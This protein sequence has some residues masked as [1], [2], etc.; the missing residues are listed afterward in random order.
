MKPARFTA[1]CLLLAACSADAQAPVAEA[2]PIG[3]L[4]PPGAVADQFPR[5]ARPVAD[6]VTDTWSQ[7][8]I[9]DDAG[10]ATT[11]MRLLGVKA[12]QTIADI[13]AGSGYYTVRLAEVVGPK[14]RVIGQDIMPLYLRGLAER[15]RKTGWR[16]ITLA[17]GDP[18]DPRLPP[19]SLD[20]ALMVH[21]Y[22][23]IE[24]PYGLLWNL[25]A[26]LKPGG[27]IGIVDA[28]RPTQRHGTPP[29]LLRCELA[30]VGYRQTGFHP[31]QPGQYLAIFVLDAPP[32]S[33]AAIRPCT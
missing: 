23:E 9:R 17:L 32:A 7:E 27:I 13:G 33:P 26:S 11:V 24:Q 31:L 4:A 14:G 1:F 3:K 8:H 20:I 25:R 10:E 30:A 15:V 29:K 28:D 21:M 6:I 12:G 5:P 19:Q 18:H 2:L 22:H 16:N